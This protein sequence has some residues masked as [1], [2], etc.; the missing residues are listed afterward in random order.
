MIVADKMPRPFEKGWPVRERFPEEYPRH[1]D[2][3]HSGCNQHGIFSEWEMCQV[4][5]WQE[6]ERASQLEIV[7]KRVRS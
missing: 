5:P 3:S 7:F 6:Y 1:N 2:P 4:C